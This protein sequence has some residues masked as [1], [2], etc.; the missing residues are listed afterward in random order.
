MK[1]TLQFHRRRNISTKVIK[2]YTAWWPGVILEGDLGEVISQ[3]CHI[4]PFFQ[5]QGEVVLHGIYRKNIPKD[6]RLF[7]ITE[8]SQNFSLFQICR[9]TPGWQKNTETVQMENKA[10]TISREKA[11]KEWYCPENVENNIVAINK[12]QIK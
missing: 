5:A 8:N 6:S 2:A 4:S 10:K 1:L 3:N 11:D 12:E 7:K 9:I